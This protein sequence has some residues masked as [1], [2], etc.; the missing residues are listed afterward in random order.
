MTVGLPRRAILASVALTFCVAAVP[1]DIGGCGQ[2]IQELDATV[3]FRAK[4][5]IDCEKCETCSFRAEACAR[6][7]DP[8]RVE[9]A[10]FP[11]RCLPLVHDGE[12]CLR[13][14]LD[15]SCE[16]YT[17]YVRDRAP[18]VPTECNFCPASGQ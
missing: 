15:A 2:P 1:G 16:E 6:A 9:S 13:S 11:E 4:A 18:E 8:D 17:A 5:F 7:C 14:L 3:F 10:K 12:V